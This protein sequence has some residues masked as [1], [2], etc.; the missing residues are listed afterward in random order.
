[1]RNLRSSRWRLWVRSASLLLW[2]ALMVL[3][4]CLPTLGVPRGA[5]EMGNAGVY[6]ETK[7]ALGTALSSRVLPLRVQVKP[8]KASVKLD[9]EAEKPELA[10]ARPERQPGVGVSSGDWDVYVTEHGEKP[11]VSLVKDTGSGSIV[12]KNIFFDPDRATVEELRK[13]YKNLLEK[14]L[15]LQDQLGR[16]SRE[17]D[18]LQK[19]LGDL[20]QALFDAGIP[21]NLWNT[22][23]N[24]APCA[25]M[26]E[27]AR[28]QC[29]QE[30]RAIESLLQHCRNERST[31]DRADVSKN[32][33]ASRSGGMPSANMAN[34][35][36]HEAQHY[37]YSA[38]SGD[39]QSERAPGE[40]AGS[41][42]DALE[43]APQRRSVE[44]FA[45]SILHYIFFLIAVAFSGVMISRYVQHVPTTTLEAGANL[46]FAVLAMLLLFSRLILRRDPLQVMR[47]ASGSQFIF[48]QCMLAVTYPTLWLIQLI[49]LGRNESVSVS[50]GAAV[51]SPRPGV[52]REITALAGPLR[53]LISAWL[54]Y[55]FFSVSWDG[56]LRDYHA[57]T[58]PWR[59][60]LWAAAAA[61]IS[62]SYAQNGRPSLVELFQLLPRITS[63]GLGDVESSS[64]MSASADAEAL[65]ASPVLRHAVTVNDVVLLDSRG[66]AALARESTTK[67]A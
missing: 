57:Q 28:L 67:K 7:Q 64:A 51:L 1:M 41:L 3:A 31:Q 62:L 34:G 18:I 44:A 13:E 59:Y 66:A 20:R 40:G 32:T 14:D 25:A 43:R 53:L 47:S 29:A 61:I 54:G 15:K 45:I 37:G 11:I 35:D 49:R 6:A 30:K 12:M 39:Q 22:R 23:S 2:S 38:Q 17:R 52:P 21:R 46:L 9:A 58:S 48:L 55:D 4:T 36:E 33:H 42:V 10:K 26:L 5:D 24:G 56:V 16:V 63:F 50:V 8:D 60:A 65:N 27:S 19:V